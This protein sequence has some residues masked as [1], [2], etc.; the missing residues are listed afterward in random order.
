MQDDADGA[1]KTYNTPGQ[2][3]RMQDILPRNIYF[4]EEYWYIDYI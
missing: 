1:L 4:K 3:A 2:L